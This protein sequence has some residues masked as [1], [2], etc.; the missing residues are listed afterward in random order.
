[1]LGRYLA[2]GLVGPADPAQAR[3][4]LQ[5]AQKAGVAEA[6]QDLAELDRA[7][8]APAAQGM[9]LQPQGRSV[10]AQ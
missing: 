3:V 6:A 5:H 4:M 1:M 2:R 9:A 10:A 8:S 7:A